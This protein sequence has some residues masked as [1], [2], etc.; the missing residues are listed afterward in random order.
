MCTHDDPDV[1]A[2]TRLVRRLCPHREEEHLMDCLGGPGYGHSEC[3]VCGATTQ[4]WTLP[5]HP[6]PEQRFDPR[7]REPQD[8]YQ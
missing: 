5:T 2:W 1:T 3:T 7:E 4:H 8:K 6:D